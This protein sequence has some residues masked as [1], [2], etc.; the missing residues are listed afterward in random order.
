M[1]QGSD[2]LDRDCDLNRQSK[3]EIPFS[4]PIVETREGNAFGERIS[5][6]FCGPIVLPFKLSGNIPMFKC[7][8]S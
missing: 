4:A 6:V 8:D 5:C 7:A 1:P 3:N 2:I